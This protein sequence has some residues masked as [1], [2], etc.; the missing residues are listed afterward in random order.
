MPPRWIALTVLVA[1]LSLS[2]YFRRRA[3]TAGEV[4][5]R[6]REG[7]AWLAARLA[8]G[9]SL[10]ALILMHILAPGYMQWA[11]FPIF[12]WLQWVGVAAG[13]LVVPLVYWVFVSLGPNVSET[14]LTKREHCLVTNGPYRW[15]RHPL[16]ATAS[17][18]LLALGLMLAS[19]PV[20]L[21]ALLAAVLVRLLVIPAE[22]RHLIAKFG[23]DYRA[24]MRRT[25]RLLPRP[26][27]FRRLPPRRAPV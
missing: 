3:R 17:T 22:E 10:L 18:M 2:A 26:A 20:L 9:L 1:T 4:I 15:V 5:P 7:G 11:S 27:A 24:Y 25:G 13:V 8:G 16:Y 19:W 14:V 6:R 21:G 12:R 23:D